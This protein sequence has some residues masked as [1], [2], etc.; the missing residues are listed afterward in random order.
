MIPTDW[1]PEPTMDRAAIEEAFRHVATRP[2][3]AARLGLSKQTLTH[4]S[5]KHPDFPQPIRRWGPYQFYVAA[6]VI[7]WYR[8]R[9]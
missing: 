5:R 7:D 9:G 8:S 1:T 3:I 4:L 2:Q 6:E